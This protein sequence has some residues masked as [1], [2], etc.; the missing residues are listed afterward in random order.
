M[1]ILSGWLGFGL[2]VVLVFVLLRISGLSRKAWT[3]FFPLAWIGRVWLYSKDI[4]KRVDMRRKGIWIRRIFFLSIIV[5]MWWDLWMLHYLR[6]HVDL[7]NWIDVHRVTVNIWFVS[8]KVTSPFLF[9]QDNSIITAFLFLGWLIGWGI[10]CAIPAQLM[11]VEDFCGPKTIRNVDDKG[12]VSHERVKYGLIEVAFNVVNKV[13]GYVAKVE[14]INSVSYRVTLHAGAVTDQEEMSRMIPRMEVASGLV[15]GGIEQVLNAPN[16]WNVRA[17][18]GLPIIKDGRTGEIRGNVPIDVMPFHPDRYRRFFRMHPFPLSRWEYPLAL[19]PEIVWANLK[20]EDVNYGLFGK[21]GLGKTRL[22]VWICYCLHYIDRLTFTVLIDL[23]KEGRGLSSYQYDPADLEAKPDNVQMREYLRQLAPLP[24]FLLITTLDDMRYFMD[25]LRQIEQLRAQMIMEHPGVEKVAD[26]EDI[27]S[28]PWLKT[29]GK[30][31]DIFDP[32]R[33]FR[34]HYG[35]EEIGSTWRQFA[36][37]TEWES[38]YSELCGFIFRCRDMK[39]NA[40]LLTQ[41]PT[42]DEIGRVRPYLTRCGFGLDA[43]TNDFVYGFKFTSRHVGGL[44][45]IM[46]SQQS[47]TIGFAIAPN[48]HPSNL[49][50]MMADAAN[51]MSEDELKECMIIKTMLTRQYHPILLKR[52]RD[53]KWKAH[54]VRDIDPMGTWQQ[55]RDTLA[56]KRKNTEERI[57]ADGIQKK[58]VSSKKVVSS[59]GH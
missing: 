46:R 40:T 45:S 2:I 58:I 48:C 17:S 16:V 13:R 32:Q 55:N 6:H 25:G 28:S 49:A 31:F 54:K 19:D 18:R 26:F 38:A 10:L 21:M 11:Q 5:L 53:L 8:F 34:I 12:N 15:Y 20:Q 33:E 3:Q 57:K 9:V 14:R 41:H 52:M 7:P 43:A 39:F 42:M 36:G 4:K 59:N 47:S 1:N 51:R 50:K 44:F 56:I 30:D 23:S 27:E 24:N 37:S 22:Y 35:I 29:M